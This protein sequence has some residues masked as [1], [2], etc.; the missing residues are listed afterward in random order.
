MES[1]GGPGYTGVHEQS[2]VSRTGYVVVGVRTACTALLTSACEVG[3]QLTCTSSCVRPTPHLLLV[4]SGKKRADWPPPCRSAQG[5]PATGTLCARSLPGCRPQIRDRRKLVGAPPRPTAERALCR[6][7]SIPSL[8]W[9]S[10]ETESLSCLLQ[11]GKGRIGVVISSYMHFTNVSARY[12]GRPWASVAPGQGGRLSR[13]APPATPS[14]QGK[15]HPLRVRAAE[16]DARVCDSHPG[17]G[18][19]AGACSV[20]PSQKQQGRASPRSLPG[21][22]TPCKDQWPWPWQFA[23]P[24]P[25][26]CTVQNFVFGPS[27]FL[28]N[29]GHE[30][31]H[32]SRFTDG[33]T[34]ARGGV[35]CPVWSPG[36]GRATMGP[37]AGTSGTGGWREP[38]G[39]YHACQS[40]VQKRCPCGFVGAALLSAHRPC[41]QRPLG[42][43]PC[44]GQG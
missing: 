36:A 1:G 7:V 16:K 34:E 35:S 11:G 8:P 29:P 15:Q 40:L 32:H 28:S 42:S 4:P 3:V 30:P 5:P 41:S 2:C 12:E 6:P 20:D 24:R 26:E 18:E 21:Y 43:W 44:R 25:L 27:V 23:C 39:T 13:P 37:L 38:P 22:L 10:T 14:L 31:S 19:A 9:E 17:C 33:K